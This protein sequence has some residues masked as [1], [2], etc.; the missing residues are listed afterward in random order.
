[1]DTKLRGLLKK[2]WILAA[3]VYIGLVAL[4][5]IALYVVPSV[6]GM[7][8]RTYIAEHGRID[9]VDEVSGFIVRDE[10][11]YA[12]AQNSKI[13]RIAETDVLIKGGTKI[14]ELTPTD[15][16]VEEEPAE[17]AGESEE[18]GD[19]AA[20]KTKESGDSKTEESGDKDTAKEGEGGKSD[21][22]KDA[23]AEKAAEEEPEH[24]GKYTDMMAE[25]GDA[26]RYTEDGTGRTPG[27]ICY[28]IDGAETKLSKSNLDNLSYDDLKSLTSRKAVKLPANK[29]SKGYPVFKVIRNSKWYLV[30]FIDNEAAEKYYSG[31]SVTIDLNGEDVDVTVSQVLTGDKQSRITLTCRTFFEGFADTRTLDT[32]I[33]AVS[34]EGLV[35]EDASIVEAPDGKRGVFVKNKLGEHVFTP[36]KVKADDGVKCVVYSDIY[37]DDEGNYVET[38]SVY[39]EII[40]EPTEEDIAGL[41]K[42]D[43]SKDDK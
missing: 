13:E 6:A 21:E 3:L 14:V 32:K 22:D 35:L 40:A 18:S 2:K 15:E 1:M 23:E 34:A 4:C 17:E 16:P 26:V 9:V 25:I 42:T 7:F 43:K 12:A 24:L 11:V 27:Y 28:S 20:D 19:K 8:E 38:I 5:C 29:C 41:A 10:V 39:D 36:V 31:A 33:T 30:F 37:V